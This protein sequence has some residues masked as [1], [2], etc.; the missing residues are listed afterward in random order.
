MRLSL[1]NVRFAYRRPRLVVRDFDLQ[2]ESGEVVAIVGPSGCGKTT[3]MRILAGV[4]QN[5]IAEGG[6]LAGLIVYGN[7]EN[8]GTLRREHQLGYMFQ[9]PML[10]PFLTVR[11]NIAFPFQGAASKHRGEVEGL[12][13]LMGLRACSDA[14]PATLSGGMKTRVALAR[15]FVTRPRLLLL[16]EPFSSLD[17]AWRLALYNELIAARSA[18]RPTTILVTHDLSEALLLADSVVL[19]GTNGTLR[20]TYQPDSRPPRPIDLASMRVFLDRQHTLTSEIQ[21]A[22]NADVVAARRQGIA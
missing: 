19:M 6:E 2:V 14:H 22:L 3:L 10:F 5:P 20:F 17:I 16:D 13:E 18:E 21:F 7:D 1:Q 9:A 11:Q 4:L 12:I 8:P 15:T